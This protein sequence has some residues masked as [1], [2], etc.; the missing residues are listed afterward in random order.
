MLC[1]ENQNQLHFGEYC[2]QRVIVQA[3][4][5][6]NA[7]DVGKAG[8]EKFPSSSHELSGSSHHFNRKGKLVSKVTS[9]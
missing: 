3:L 8:Q 2:I 4:N 9:L 1:V 6:G 7:S 5:F